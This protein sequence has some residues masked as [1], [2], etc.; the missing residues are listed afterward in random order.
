[1]TKTFKTAVANAKKSDLHEFLQLFGEM[2]DCSPTQAIDLDWLHVLALANA[3][4]IEAT[5][6]TGPEDMALRQR[7]I[8][9]KL[10]LLAALAEVW[11][12]HLE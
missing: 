1:M 2:P 4:I 7:K 9:R 3:D 11:S 6:L 5:R 12:E 8:R 10:A